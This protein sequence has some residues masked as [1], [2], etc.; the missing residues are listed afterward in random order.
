[1]ARSGDERYGADFS[2]FCIS[3]LNEILG[4][5][6]RFIMCKLLES[7]L[8]SSELYSPYLSQLKTE[9]ERGREVSSGHDSM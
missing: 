1:M 9:Y 7:G 2:Y 8:L 6:K 4:Q 5:S 3:R